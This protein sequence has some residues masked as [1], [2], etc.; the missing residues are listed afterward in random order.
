MN[1]KLHEMK[2][3]CFVR[4]LYTLFWLVK[5]G[6]ATQGK[7]RQSEMA[8]TPPCQIQVLGNVPPHFFRDV[9]SLLARVFIFLIDRAT[10]D[11]PIQNI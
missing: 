2:C 6:Q 11:V 1:K 9:I 3:C 7:T 8:N 5:L 10:Q 4:P